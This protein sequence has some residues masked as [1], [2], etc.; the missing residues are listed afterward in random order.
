MFASAPQER[1]PGASSRHPLAHARGAAAPGRSAPAPSRRGYCW[2]WTRAAGR[3][4]V[5]LIG[6]PQGESLGTG[7][8]GK[9]GG[10]VTR[11]G[12]RTVAARHAG[13][14]AGEHQ[15]N[16]CAVANGRKSVRGW[17]AKAMKP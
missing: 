6:V 14:T 2:G 4:R 10:G 3:G 1:T 17:L 11:Y 12:V 16:A 9:L 7:G 8:F 5:G 15:H 13:Y